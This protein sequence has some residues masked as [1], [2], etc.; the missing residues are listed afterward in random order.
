[1]PRTTPV[2][3]TVPF[4]EHEA[5]WLWEHLFTLDLSH[6]DRR[7]AAIVNR[8]LTRLEIGAPPAWNDNVSEGQP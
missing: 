5:N 4:T 7:T 6:C 8:T 3:V 2:E 1:M